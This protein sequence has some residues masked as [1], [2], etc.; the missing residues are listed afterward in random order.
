MR[1]PARVLL[2]EVDGTELMVR[3]QATPARARDGAALADEIIGAL[4][5]VTGEQRLEPGERPGAREA[6]T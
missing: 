1:A 3:V 4:R 5:D 6:R 2:E